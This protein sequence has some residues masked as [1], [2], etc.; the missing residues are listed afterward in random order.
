MVS[1]AKKNSRVVSS[2]SDSVIPRR[3]ALS[4]AMF[5]AEASRSEVFNGCSD[6][7]EMFSRLAKRSYNITYEA[8]TIHL[9]HWYLVSLMSDKL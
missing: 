4:S 1:L 3:L 6:Q 8:L 9:R 5:F 7:K 2:A